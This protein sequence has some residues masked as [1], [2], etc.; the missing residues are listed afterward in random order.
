MTLMHQASTGSM[1]PRKAAALH[2]STGIGSNPDNA[3]CSHLQ[4]LLRLGALNSRRG[5]CSQRNLGWQTMDIC[6]F[7]WLPS[8]IKL[9]SAK[10]A[11]L[12]IEAAGTAEKPTQ[13]RSKQL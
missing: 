4:C 12:T 10:H 7:L 6:Y 2:T 5:N 3:S 1:N 8:V 11:P 9:Q 13:K